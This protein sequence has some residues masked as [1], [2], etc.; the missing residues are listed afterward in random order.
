MIHRTILPTLAL[1]LCASMATAAA[2]ADRPICPPAVPLVANDPYFS[3]WSFDDTLTDGPTRHWTGKEHPLTCLIRVDGKPHRLMGPDHANPALS[4]TSV[5]VLPT[6]TIY[7][8]ADEQV[9]VTLTFLT[10]ALP[11]DLDVLARPVTYVTWD[12]ASA[13]GQAHDVVIKFGADARIGVNMPEQETV[14]SRPEVSGLGVVR[15]GSK[16][17]PVLEKK[18]DDLRIDWGYLY[19]AAAAGQGVVQDPVAMRFD[20]GKVEASPVSRTLVLAYDDE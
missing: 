16:E 11:D 15:V 3:I 1:A 6:R 20:L 17:Q 10:P 14:V 9:E 2:A 13:D 4:Q 7:A 8:F 5:R 18:G 12:V 19:L